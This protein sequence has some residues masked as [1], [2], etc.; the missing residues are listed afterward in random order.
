[1]FKTNYSQ[2]EFPPLKVKMKAKRKQSN[3]RQGKAFKVRDLFQK[4]ATGNVPEIAKRTV[5]NEHPTF[6]NWDRFFQN[7]DLEDAR[8]LHTHMLERKENI[9]NE[10]NTLRNNEL[11]NLKKRELEL[12]DRITEL[13]KNQA[14]GASD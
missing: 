13:E 4:M 3:T 10:R 5:W 2:K 8:Q 12:Q 7:L 9:L 14:P 6:D 11:E 1:M